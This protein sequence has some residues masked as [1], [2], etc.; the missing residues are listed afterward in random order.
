MCF[1][2]TDDWS[3]NN[4]LL[5]KRERPNHEHTP[6]P[7]GSFYLRMAAALMHIATGG[8]GVARKHGDMPVPA[9]RQS[10]PPQGRAVHSARSAPQHRRAG[11]RH[12]YGGSSGLHARRTSLVSTSSIQSR[13][14]KTLSEITAF[15][16]LPA[17]APEARL[18]AAALTPPAAGSATAGSPQVQSAGSPVNQDIW[19]AVSD[20]RRL[21]A[22]TSD[23]ADEAGALLASNVDQQ[24]WGAIEAIRKTAPPGESCSACNPL[25]RDMSEASGR[26]PLDHLS[27]PEDA[28]SA[29]QVEGGDLDRQLYRAI[30]VCPPPIITDPVCALARPPLCRAQT[31]ASDSG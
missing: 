19:R 1:H 6:Q 18:A 17:V 24:L 27:M 11:L 25:F 7:G 28:D 26:S 16:S 15:Q 30:E 23:G 2:R 21:Q 12:R 10:P 8:G 13:L 20:I 29:G 5:Q 31:L 4:S 14:D 22:L 3:L 9:A